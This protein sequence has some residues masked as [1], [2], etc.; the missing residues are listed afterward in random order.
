MGEW[1]G[2]LLILLGAY[3]L[4]HTFAGMRRG[5]F[6]YHIWH[7][8]MHKEEIRRDLD[9]HAFNVHVI[10]TLIVNSFLLLFGL[11]EAFLGDIFLH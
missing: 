6:H 1:I 10:V 4:F 2:L 11:Y 8:G 7:Q 3:G 9:R 5:V